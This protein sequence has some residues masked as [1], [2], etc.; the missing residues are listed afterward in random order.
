MDVFRTG[1]VIDILL[2]ILSST[3]EL[4]F[5][6]SKPVRGFY[7]LTIS[8]KPSKEDKKLLGLTGAEVNKLLNIS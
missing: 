1:L 6:Q 7:K 4:N 3:Y 8:A 2:S 5:M